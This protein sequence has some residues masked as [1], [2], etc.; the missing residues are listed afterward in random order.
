METTSTNDQA[1]RVS[2]SESTGQ[3]MKP[4]SRW[5]RWIMR[6]LLLEF[7]L[8]FAFLVGEVAVRLIAPQVLFPRY[9]TGSPL[10]IRVPVPNARYTHTS[11][12]MS[13]E[14]RLNA[15]GIRSDREY[16]MLK[17][18]GVFRIVGL[19]DSFT[20]GYEVNVE[21]TY[22]YQ[23][24]KILK[25]RGYTVEV[26]NLGVS[27]FGNAEELIFLKKFGFR[28]DPDVVIVGHFT[29]DIIDNMR[30]NLFRLDENDKLVREAKEY[31]PAIGLRDKLYSIWAYRFLAEHSHLLA[32]LRERVA[33]IVKREIV[34]TQQKQQKKNNGHKDYS[35]RLT[36]RL[37]DE[38]KIVCDARGVRF[39]VLDIP[40]AELKE[41]KV[42]SDY[43]NLVTENEIVR[44]APRLRAEGEGA[45]L[46]RRKGH[47]HWTPRA[48]RI[49][50]ELLA[51]RLTGTDGN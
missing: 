38:M 26:I 2:E 43:V 20:Q 27:G 7:S 6:L 13:V 25:E 17:P 28:F 1:I 3:P 36:G 15:M 46:Y 18:P 23:L 51:D 39:L 14:F 45:Y 10:G 49:A 11:P 31:L 35:L 41:T 9:V 33:S 21:E 37:I 24:E 34:T 44:T 8:M 19:G 16:T 12:E 29:N 42:L 30:C 22:L 47:R 4:P 50:A 48:H 32:L 5:R 40:S